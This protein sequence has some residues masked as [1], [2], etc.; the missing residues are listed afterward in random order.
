MKEHQYTALV[1]VQLAVGLAFD[2]KPTLT[3]A[4]D[5]ALQNF[6]NHPAMKDMPTLFGESKIVF[7]P[8]LKCDV[9]LGDGVRLNGKGIIERCDTCEKYKSD[10]EAWLAAS[11]HR[12]D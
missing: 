12:E 8:Q 4:Q 10:H 1:T 6:V 9:C 5:A 7:D 2:E 11:P 3:E